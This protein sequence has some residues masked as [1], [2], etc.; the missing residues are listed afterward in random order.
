M[1]PP[2]LGAF[3]GAI[4]HIDKT[5]AR[6]S[7]LA[8]STTVPGLLAIMTAPKKALAEVSLRDEAISDEGKSLTKRS[9]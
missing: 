3:I 6:K 7:G 8:I 2:V 4:L 1:I 9:G 5:N